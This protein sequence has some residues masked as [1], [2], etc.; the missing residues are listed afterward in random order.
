VPDDLTALAQPDFILVAWAAGL[1]LVSGYVASIRLV[2]P[3]FTWMTGSLAGLLALAGAFGENSW[4]ARFGLIT[5]ALGLVWARNRQLSGIFQLAAGMAFLF[6]ASV[7]GGWVPAVSA[8]IVLGGVT[9]EMALAHWYLVDPRLPR[10]ILKS[11]AVAGL[12]GIVADS[13]VLATAGLPGG[14]A[15]LA[16]WALMATSAAL[17]AGAFAALRYP[18]YSGV[19]AATGLSYLAVLTTLGGVFLGRVLVAGLGPFGT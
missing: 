7:V 4:W 8:T 3:G 16:F 14:G 13:I 15:T 19:M 12:A 1:A 11:L 5:M 18:A 17:M 9:G 10:S 2:G 6:Q